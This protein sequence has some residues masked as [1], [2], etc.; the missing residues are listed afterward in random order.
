MLIGSSAPRGLVR[1]SITGAMDNLID[2]SLSKRKLRFGR[3]WL[4]RAA[5]RIDGAIE[6]GR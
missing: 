1:V 4:I 2:L 5:I 3:A 6:P